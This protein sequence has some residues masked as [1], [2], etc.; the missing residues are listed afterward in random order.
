MG[1]TT[2]SKLAVADARKGI[3]MFSELGV[4]TLAMVENMAFFDCEGGT[5]HYPFGKGIQEF[6]SAMDEIRPDN[7]CQL[8]ISSYAND[9]T[10]DGLPLTLARPAQAETE[11]AAMSQLARIVSS[12]LLKLPFRP[13]SSVGVA[14]FDDATE[15]FE[16]SSIQ[17]S[18]ENGTFLLR[19]FSEEG[20]IQRRISPHDLRSRDPKTG[21]VI[22]DDEDNKVDSAS[23]KGRGMVE[24]HR[25]GATKG[26]QRNSPERLEKKGKVGFEVTWGDGAKYIY[27]RR[28]VTMAGGGKVTKS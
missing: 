1:V 10:E 19:A 12:E 20:A 16:L 8:P 7:I 17:L 9:A 5:R 25:A 4:A 18:L 27:S 15:K 26:G 22:D 11:L 14:V 3:Q 6:M 2:P 24:I 13:E 28:A 23:E 21:V